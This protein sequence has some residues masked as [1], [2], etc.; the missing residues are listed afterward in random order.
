TGLVLDRGQDVTTGAGLIE[1]FHARKE[2]LGALLAAVL[3]ENR[4]IGGLFP[5]NSNS[6][7]ASAGGSGAS[8]PAPGG[9]LP[10]ST[11]PNA[12]ASSSAA[13]D[14]ATDANGSAAAGGA[15]SSGASGEPTAVH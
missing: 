14:S 2:V 6:P 11:A 10:G 9:A 8:T 5:K 1:V 15:S 4:L 7:R 3:V 13:R 12:A